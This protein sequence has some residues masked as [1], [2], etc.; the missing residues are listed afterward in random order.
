M[1]HHLF[2]FSLCL[3]LKDAHFLN[4]HDYVSMFIFFFQDFLEIQI[5]LCFLEFVVRTS[6]VIAPDFGR[7]YRFITKAVSCENQSR[8]TRFHLHRILMKRHSPK[9]VWL[10]HTLQQLRLGWDT[11]GVFYLPT[12]AQLHIWWQ[13]SFKKT[14]K[15][16]QIVKVLNCSRPVIWSLEIGNHTASPPLRQNNL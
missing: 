1:Q 16:K 3:N 9:S 11:L 6:L 4:N 2:Y 8:Q 10:R 13:H 7:S 14:M 15:V 5:Q 12:V